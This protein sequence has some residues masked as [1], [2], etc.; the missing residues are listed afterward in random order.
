MSLMAEEPRAGTS[1]MVMSEP[2]PR[3]NALCFCV[4]MVSLEICAGLGL[5]G[6]VLGND[7]FGQGYV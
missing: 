3:P 7:F 5:L 1:S 4:M 6:V 2:N